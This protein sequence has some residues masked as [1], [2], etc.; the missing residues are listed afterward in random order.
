M[1]QAGGRDSSHSSSSSHEGDA[2]KKYKKAKKAS[3]QPHI[4]VNNVLEIANVKSDGSLDMRAETAEN[5]KQKW[6]RQ[7]M[8]LED[9]I[10]PTYGV[11][12]Y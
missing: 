9:M 3:G 10:E 11:S 7:H 4:S 5:I 6:D 1:S 8:R 12:I 2:F